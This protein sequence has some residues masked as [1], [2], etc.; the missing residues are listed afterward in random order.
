M[1]WYYYQH[2]V[3]IL[4][5]VLASFSFCRDCCT[6]LVGAND[7]TDTGNDAAI[8]DNNDDDNDDDDDDDDDLDINIDLGLLESMGQPD[9]L[10]LLDDEKDQDAVQD[11]ITKVVDN[12]VDD[13]DDDDDLSMTILD[14]GDDNKGDQ[15]VPL[16]EIIGSEDKDENGDSF[17]DS[18]FDYDDFGNGNDGGDMY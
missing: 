12:E 3:C 16:E 9:D 2:L 11:D 13:M 5:V 6:L 10:N 18:G 1:R 15:M 17:D 8:D 14:D 4:V 7:T